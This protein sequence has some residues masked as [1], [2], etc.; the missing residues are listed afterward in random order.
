M[1]KKILTI[2]LISAL[3]LFSCTQNN[4]KN[5]ENNSGNTTEKNISNTSSWSTN[6][7]KENI[8]NIDKAKAILKAF[9]NNNAEVTKYMNPEK[10]IQHN[11]WAA[12]WVE[13]FKNTIAFFKDKGV[14]VSIL[15]EFEDWNFVI[16]H[17]NYNYGDFETSTFDV[18]HFENGL[19]TE[20]WDNTQ[21]ITENTLNWSSMITWGNELID[22]AKTAENKALVEKFTNDVL[23]DKKTEDIEKYFSS[24]F[25]QHD[26]AT[27]A[28]TAG[29]KKAL[30]KINYE[31]IHKIL[32]QWNFVLVMSEAKIWWESSS[33]YDLYR[34]EDWKIIEH[35]ATTEKIPPK[36]EWK[37]QNWKF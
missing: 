35:W 31:K 3:I 1:N 37:N 17:S 10:Y 8:S 19:A 21:A 27:A 29:I 12:D 6:S 13:A 25:I 36:T 11:L 9:E 33:I 30:E 26:P 23:K 18:F 22:E 20:H 28:W 7:S 15:R 14:G 5:I 2:G 4:S 16:L 24:K 34:L 32:W